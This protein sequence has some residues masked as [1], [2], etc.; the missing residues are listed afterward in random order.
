MHDY[1][2]DYMTEYT[3]LRDVEDLLE[4][5]EQKRKKKMK[6]VYMIWGFL[7]LPFLILTILDLEYIGLWGI[8]LLATS[9]IVLVFYLVFK[10][11]VKN[12]VLYNIIYPRAVSLFNNEHD[13]IFDFAFKPKLEKTFNQEMGLFTRYASVSSKYQMKAKTEIGETVTIQEC[14]LVT[15][16]GKSSTLH[17]RGIY[18]ILPI[19]GIPHQQFRT[20]SKPRLKDMKFDRLEEYPENRFYVPEGKTARDVNSFLLQVFEELPGLF[21]LKQHYVASNTKEVHLALWMRHTPGMP[22]E[23]TQEELD[24]IV[25]PLHQVM[26]YTETLLNRYLEM[27]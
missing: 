22:S 14:S 24:L 1:D 9:I 18:I 27:N 25:D 15:S 2:P 17:F 23:I 20:N 10:S 4:E 3:L 13:L 19:T 12:R 8:I 7:Q 11:Q 5:Q 16:N 26:Q 6:T 21:D